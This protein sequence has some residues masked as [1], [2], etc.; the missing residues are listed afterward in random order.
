MLTAFT[1]AT[2]V[3][4]A[5]ES[6]FFGPIVPT[7]CETCPCGFAGVLEIMRHLMNFAV[8]FGVI[9][10]TIMLAWGGFMYILSAANPESR[11]QANKVL[12]G[13]VIGMVLILSSW[14]IVDF[15]MRTL[16]SGPDGTQGKYGP[17]NSILAESADWCIVAGDTKPLF[18]LIPFSE[19]PSTSPTNPAPNPNQPGGVVGSAGCPSCVSLT[20]QGLTC[21]SSNSCTIDPGVAP[22]LAALKNSF[23]GTW[24]ITE[25]YPPTVTHSNQCHR[26]GTCVDAGFRGN[27][28]Y[29][30]S[31]VT[32]FANAAK[33]AGLRPV[34]ETES[35]GLRDQARQAGVTAYCKS[36]NGY[37]HI[38]GNHFSLYG[39]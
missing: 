13:A 20:Q 2:P 10:L 38:T 6:T 24:T 12:T 28:V 19:G 29:N 8:S 15:V 36:D 16:Y 7:Q 21:K 14:L 11:S 35:C 31:N 3:A 1:L 18:T 5:A 34:F 4:F 26:N 27:T 25:A 9:V 32:A 17:W 30:A 22:K 33:G 37:G 23:S 39:N